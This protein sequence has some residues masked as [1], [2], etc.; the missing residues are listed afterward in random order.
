MI[1]EDAGKG[2]ADMPALLGSILSIIHPQRSPATTKLQ[3]LR[4]LEFHT[5]KAPL[6]VVLSHGCIF[7]KCQLLRALGSRSWTWCCWKPDVSL[8]VH[9]AHN[10]QPTLLRLSAGCPEAA[11]AFRLKLWSELPWLA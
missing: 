3:G 7:Q 9:L 8:L 11:P 6:P 4:G 2:T 10:F 1:T 5:G